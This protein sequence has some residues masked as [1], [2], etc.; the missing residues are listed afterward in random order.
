MEKKQLY[1]ELFG[2][3]I[4]VF[5]FLFFYFFDYICIFL[6]KKHLFKQNIQRLTVKKL[7]PIMVVICHLS[8]GL[9]KVKEM[10][11]HG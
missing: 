5:L 4:A 6:R 1:L 2:F 3:K 11:Y 10:C 9:C 7:L 8:T